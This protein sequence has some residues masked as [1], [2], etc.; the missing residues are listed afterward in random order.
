MPFD[1]STLGARFRDVDADLEAVEHSKIAEALR[2]AAAEIIPLLPEGTV[3]DDFLAALE[4]AAVEAHKLVP[5]VSAVVTA[6]GGLAPAP[7]PV[8]GLTTTESGTTG[9]APVAAQEGT[10]A[11][12]GTAVAADPTQPGTAPA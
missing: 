9:E 7:A 11:P 3:V 6:E 10:G 1:L 8:E 2:T 12:E 5:A 4:K